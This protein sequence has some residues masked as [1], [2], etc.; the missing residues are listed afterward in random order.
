MNFDHD[1]VQV[2]KL[3]E[4]QKKKCF[5]SSPTEEHFFPQIQVKAKKKV[6]TKN[7]TLFFP[8]FSGHL[9]SDVHQSQIIGGGMQM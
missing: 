5:H 6:F 3:S 7:K 4:D 9:R 2:R 1:F 8:E